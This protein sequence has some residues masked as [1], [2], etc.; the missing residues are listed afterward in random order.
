MQ[1]QLPQI[2]ESPSSAH[3]GMVSSVKTM[4]WTFLEMG[5]P[6]NSP[7][8]WDILGFSIINHHVW[9]TPINGNPHFEA[10]CI[11]VT[12]CCLIHDLVWLPAAFASATPTGLPHQR[13]FTGQ[14]ASIPARDTVKSCQIVL[15]FTG[16]RTYR[17][18]DTTSSCRRG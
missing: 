1:T 16:L 8:I 4:T 12:S 3:P 2:P 5:V 9:D 7:F 11:H 17:K 14:G 18:V 13:F 10:W 6:P 15:Q